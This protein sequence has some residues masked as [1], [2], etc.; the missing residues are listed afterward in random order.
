MRRLTCIVALALLT[1]CGSTGEDQGGSS[2]VSS[3]VAVGADVPSVELSP[4]LGRPAALAVAD[5]VVWVA[6]EERGVLLRLDADNGAELGPPV[7][8][9]A[10]PVAAAAAGDTVWVVDAGG[11]VTP[12]DAEIGE[13][14]D[15]VELGG[16]LVDVAA[17]GPLVWVADIERSVVH[18][19]DPED[20][21]RVSEVEVP[22]GVVR[23]AVT[24]ERLWVT[25]LDS[26]VTAVDLGTGVVGDPLP[27]GAGPIGLAVHRG[28]VWVANGDDDTVTRLDEI[29][30]APVG[31][32]IPVGPA[33]VAIAPMGD[34]VWVVEQDGRSVSRIDAL[35]GT[36]EVRSEDV[37]VRP[38]GIA[39]SGS[40]V[41]IVGVDPS[42]AVFVTRGR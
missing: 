28:T 25:N 11:T 2:S 31:D 22:A 12:V 13:A 38:R 16:T 9:S 27:V 4:L 1:G 19:I 6:D 40:G 15:P 8:V 3:P 32:P 10:V 18:S 26:T 36:I 5:G 35:T 23:I 37:G 41:W 24:G 30:G 17:R 39:A 34:D 42:V 14:G 29:T 20:V 7:A 21:A 33:P